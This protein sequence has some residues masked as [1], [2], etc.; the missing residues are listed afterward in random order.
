[1]YSP[2]EVQRLVFGCDAISGFLRAADK[3]DAG[4]AGML[5]ELLQRRFADTVGGTDRRRRRDPE[6]GRRRC[7][8]SRIGP[9]GETPLRDVNG[10][11]RKKG[12]ASVL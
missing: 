2:S 1:M 8:N 9:L 10:A 5:G 11:W 4:L 7:V 6:Q 3:I 12:V